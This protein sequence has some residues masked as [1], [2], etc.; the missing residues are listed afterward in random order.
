MAR[1]FFVTG[2]D[3]GVG[4]TTVTTALLRLLVADGYRAR[5]VKPIESGCRVS[6]DGELEPA[7]ALAH[8]RAA[9]LEHLPLERF[10]RYRLQ[11]PLAPAVAAER[12]GLS[13]DLTACVELVVAAQAETDVLLVEGAGGLLVPFTGNAQDGYQT[14]AD[15]IMALNVPA[16]VVARARL[17]TLNHTLLTVREL[18][19]RG[20][21]CVGVILNDADAETGLEREDNARV[22]RAF[23]VSVVAELPYGT[24]RPE[25]HLANVARLLTQPL[26]ARR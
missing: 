7:D 4:K 13:L 2:T 3:T 5:A 14:V 19:R 23:G 9:G 11:E 1:T 21:A 12:A 17:G 25:S 8:R 24:A 18:D 22:L 16:L 10:I 15:F 26:S 6:A 20:I